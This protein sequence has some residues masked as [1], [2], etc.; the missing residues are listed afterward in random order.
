MNPTRQLCEY[1]VSITPDMIG[2]ENMADIRLKTLDWTGCVLAAL[3]QPCAKAAQSLAADEGGAERATV[4]GMEKK[5]SAGMA[6]FTNGIISHALEY[7]DTNKIAITHPGAPVFAA[8]L[9]EAEALGADFASFAVAIAAGYETMIRLG[10]AMNPDHYDH[11]HTTGTAGTFAAAAAAGR[12]L[13]LDAAA[14]ERAF[15]LAAT[16]AAGLLYSF[17]TDAKLLTVGNAARNGLMAAEL[18]ARGFTAPEDAFAAKGG[19]AESAGAKKDLSFMIPKEGDRLLLEDAYYKMHAS[20]GHTHSALDALQNLIAEH[21]IKAEQVAYVKAGVYHKAWELCRAY[22]TQTEAKAK[23]S[24][25]YCI[26]VMLLYG[27]TTLSEFAEEI[28]QS[29][30]VKEFASRITVEEVPEFTAAYPTLRYERIEIGLKDGSVVEKTVDLPEGRPAPAFIIK[31]YY[32]LAGMTLERE[33]AEQIEKAILGIGDDD[34][35][36]CFCRL[37]RE[38]V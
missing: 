24:L 36:E 10:G 37:L 33:R 30:E 22:Q 14:M 31:K 9:A 38:A 11:W 29:D 34:S 6:A 25:P 21:G 12:L 7:D 18:A 1:I 8:A 2:A 23:F 19:Y 35:L 27:Q 13:G 32:S 4:I 16:T 28:L 3:K 15:G 5:S 17:G 26:A 20:C